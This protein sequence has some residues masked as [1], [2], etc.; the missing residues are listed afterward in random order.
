MLLSFNEKAF[1]KLKIKMQQLSCLK[2]ICFSTEFPSQ[3][4]TQHN[5]NF[6]ENRVEFYVFIYFKSKKTLFTI[7][8]WNPFL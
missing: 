6:T 5:L 2:V 3:T 4:I 8:G 7:S 1:L